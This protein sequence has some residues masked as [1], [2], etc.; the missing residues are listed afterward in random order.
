[1]ICTDK[2]EFLDRKIKEDKQNQIAI[3]MSIFLAK[4]EQQKSNGLVE[5]GY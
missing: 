4:P 2:D 3:S 5:L 1:M